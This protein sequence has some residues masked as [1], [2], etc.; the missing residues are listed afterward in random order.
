MTRPARRFDSLF[1][2]LLLAQ[3]GL[4]LVLALVI[5]ALFYVE[6]N[7]TIARLYA[8]R[9]APPLTDA[10]GLAPGPVTPVPVL[11][12]E[13]APAAT[14]MASLHAPRFAALRQALAARGVP[15]DEIRLSLGEPEPMVWLH[16]TPPQR[17]ALW[18]G[19][20]GP[21]VV[22]EWSARTLLALLLGSSLL[23][24]VSWAFTRRLTRP[25]ER[26]RARMQHH[27]PGAPA[28]ASGAE[29][30][31]PEIAAIDAAYRDLLARLQ[32]HERERAVLLAGVSHD[33]R[34]PLGRI[35]IA[36]E[37]LP[38]L[39]EVRMRRESIVRN[40][41]EADR[42]IESFLDFVRSGELPFDET[43]DLADAARAV[44]ASFE[45]PAHEL[46]LA[47]APESLPWP[48]ANRLLVERLL[49]NLVDN[50]LKHGKPP[51]IL[52]L[53]ARDGQAWIDVEDAGEGI[54][55]QWV[56][57]LQEAFTRGDSSRAGPG[58]GLGL[59]I[60]RQVATRLGG[61]VSF[62]RSDGRQRVRV[63]LAR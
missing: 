15:V 7:V 10:A 22:P 16:V 17:P 39:R 23:V 38:D 54:A 60:V 58:S 20:S 3:T 50:A 57:R 33:L 61:A 55:P 19:V 28:L 2:R 27:T 34:S 44:V 26:L 12:R 11:R 42:L 48:R 49:A 25:L 51:V 56:D 37:L 18:L 6:R 36:A 8:E 30:L 59:A 62:E 47:A 53:V 46:R 21:L 5:G 43:V 41:A 4:V 9:W 40:V 35:R 63:T 32:Q 14:R 13:A 31:T 24:G 52:T 45:R 1:A 29:T